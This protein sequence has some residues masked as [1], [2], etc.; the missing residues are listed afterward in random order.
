VAGEAEEGVE[1][2]HHPHF[3]GLLWI[4]R[5]VKVEPLLTPNN[6]VEQVPSL[7]RS[8]KKSVWFQNQYINV[9]GIG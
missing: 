7:I 4:D 9:R 1:L 2:G 3:F 5:R 8:A 6:Y